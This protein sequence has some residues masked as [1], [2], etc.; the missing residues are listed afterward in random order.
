MRSR[1]AWQAWTT[2]RLLDASRTLLFP[3]YSSLFTPVWLR[4]LGARVGHDVEASTVLLLPSLTRIDEGAFLADDTMVATYELRGGWMRLARARI[5]KR[6]FLGNSGLSAA[7]HT[8]P[9]NALV[10]VLSVAP[11]RRKPDRR[12]SDLL[13]CACDES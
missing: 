8:V 4:L 6:A 2:E 9:K 5:G 13:P 10:A 7:G 1:V 11:P 3:I 12:G